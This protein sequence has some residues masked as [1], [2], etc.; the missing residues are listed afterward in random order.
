[1]RFTG[2]ALS[3]LGIRICDYDILLLFLFMYAFIHDSLSISLDFI[4]FSC[5]LLFYSC[6]FY[7][8]RLFSV[9]SSSYLRVRD[10]YIAVIFSTYFVVHYLLA[11]IPVMLFREFHT[12]ADPNEIV[13]HKF[14]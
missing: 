3:T 11:I 13:G 8:S 2:F 10:F 12:T 6:R 5:I 9:A 4:I 7:N 14:L 1:M